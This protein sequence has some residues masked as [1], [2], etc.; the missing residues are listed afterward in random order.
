MTPLTVAAL[1]D[2][3]QSQFCLYGNQALFVLGEGD[4]N[5][6]PDHVSFDLYVREIHILECVSHDESSKDL[7][8]LQDVAEQLDRLDSQRGNAIINVSHGATLL[9]SFRVGI[10]SKEDGFIELF[11]STELEQ[12]TIVQ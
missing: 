1:N 9:K 5:I 6:N 8:G 10:N 7:C 4:E 12:Q 3:A 11:N 2:T